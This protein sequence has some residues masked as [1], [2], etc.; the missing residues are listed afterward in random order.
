MRSEEYQAEELCE[1]CRGI[2]FF[3]EFEVVAEV[4]PTVLELGD[5]EHV[6]GLEEADLLEEGDEGG[7]EG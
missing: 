3:E 2:V 1:D 4:D 6:E 7:G 5:A